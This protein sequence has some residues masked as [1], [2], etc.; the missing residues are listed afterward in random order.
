[1]SSRFTAGP[2]YREPFGRNSYLRSTRDV[3]TQSW[4]FAKG[5]IPTETIDGVSQKVLQPGTLVAKITSGDDDGKVGVFDTGASDG[6]QTE[7]NVVG[8]CDT[9]LPWQLL[10]RDHEIA[11][12]YEAAVDQSKCFQ[13]TAG[14]RAEL[15]DTAAAYVVAKKH[16]NITFPV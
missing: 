2:G 4:T 10:E 11:V 14:V 9:F 15:G 3:K 7:A 8:I 6:R 16:V 5:A 13:Y 12:V 1:M